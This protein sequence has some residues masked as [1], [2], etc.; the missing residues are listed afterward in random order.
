M[1]EGPNILLNKKG[2][3]FILLWN[4]GSKYTFLGG[5]GNLGLGGMEE[6]KFHPGAPEWL[7]RLSI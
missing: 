5:K 2:C 3:F 4:L 6:Q 1:Q 7:S